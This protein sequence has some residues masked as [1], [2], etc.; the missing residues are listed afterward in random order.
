MNRL[1]ELGKWMNKIE[2]DGIPK[3]KVFHMMWADV[4]KLLRKRI[5]EKKSWEDITAY[6]E[7]NKKT[8]QGQQERVGPDVA[9]KVFNQISTKIWSIN[10]AFEKEQ[11]RE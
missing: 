7:K 10:R 11:R 5:E 4:I 6:I 3:Q 9:Q 1:E 8:F 2:K